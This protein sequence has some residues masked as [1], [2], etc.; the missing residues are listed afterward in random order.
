ME[1]FKRY[2]HAEG[3][4]VEGEGA[5]DE[6]GE[7]EMFLTLQEKVFGVKSSASKLKRVSR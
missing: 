2:S 4:V 3:E 5:I 1:L 7:V 6:V